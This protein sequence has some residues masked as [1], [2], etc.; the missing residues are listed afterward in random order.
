MRTYELNEHQ[1]VILKEVKSLSLNN[2]FYIVVQQSKTEKNLTL[3]ELKKYIKRSV[4][5]YVRRHAPETYYEGKENMNVRYYCFFETVKEFSI[6]QH[7]DI[8]APQNLY[9][10]FHFHLFISGVEE[11]FIMELA[12]QLNSMKNKKNCI[13]K[14]DGRPLDRLDDD[15]IL[16]HAKQFQHCFSPQ[17][18]LKNYALRA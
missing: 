11:D 5:E 10:G 3:P 15:F 16:Y 8:F 17:L 1:K 2:L 18:I 14:I 7:W 9:C 6:S 12:Y 4:S 13:S